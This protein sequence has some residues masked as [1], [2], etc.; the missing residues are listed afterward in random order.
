[1]LQLKI[2]GEKDLFLRRFIIF[3][4]KPMTTIMQGKKKDIRIVPYEEKYKPFF[5]KFNEEWITKYFELEDIDR[6]LF[7]DP[8]TYIIKPGGEIFTALV[9]G[10]PGG[11]CALAISNN[12]A[13]DYEL[14]KLAVTP[15]MQG[16]G[17][18]R[19][20]VNAVIREARNRG[21]RTLYIETNT[22]LPPA[23]HLYESAGFKKIPLK[24]TVFKRV[25]VEYVLDL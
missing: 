21:G 10:E 17:L 15:P 18:G 16:L 9:D 8:Y 1:M 24:E 14:E 22:K 19:L 23:I 13:Y 3:A 25:D 4:S 11:V 2:S 12:P 6:R 5:Q 20:L 7:S